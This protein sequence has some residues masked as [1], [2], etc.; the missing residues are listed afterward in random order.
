[1]DNHIARQLLIQDPLNVRMKKYKTVVYFGIA[2][3][4]FRHRSNEDVDGLIHIAAAHCILL[5]YTINA[6]AVYMYNTVL[7]R[8]AC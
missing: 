2:C 4:S 5:T 8:A 3:Y 6:A 1:M 7:V